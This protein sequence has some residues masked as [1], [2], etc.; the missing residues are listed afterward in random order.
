ML[1]FINNYISRNILQCIHNGIISRRNSTVKQ[2]YLH[3]IDS[4]SFSSV[5]SLS[6]IRLFATPCIASDGPKVSFIAF[7]FEL[8]SS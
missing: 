1:N 8:E 2:E 3:L 6:C 5:Q 7:V 4:H